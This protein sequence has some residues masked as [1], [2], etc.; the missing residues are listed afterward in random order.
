M[1]LIHEDDA[2]EA[3]VH[4]VRHDAPGVFNVA[5]EEALPL[6]KIRGLVGNRRCC[7]SFTPWPTGAASGC[8][9]PV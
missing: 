3:L 2:V 5:A 6:S 8:V 7:R 1:Q 4:A 9:G